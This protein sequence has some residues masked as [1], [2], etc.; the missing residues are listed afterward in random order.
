MVL[1]FCCLAGFSLSRRA[2]PTSSFS[3]DWGWDVSVALT[4]LVCACR[5][6]FRSDEQR[7][8]GASR[9]GVSG[10]GGGAGVGCGVHLDRRQCG[11]EH[12]RQLVWR[13]AAFPPPPSRLLSPLLRARN[14]IHRSHPTHRCKTGSPPVAPDGASITCNVACTITNMPDM[15]AG[16]A[17]GT[18]ATGGVGAVTLVCVYV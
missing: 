14:V 6:L 17:F 1:L 8:L 5:C 9:C 16:P 2:P 7:A 18:F 15:G 10:P 12:R 11:L 3:V 4:Y 13:Y